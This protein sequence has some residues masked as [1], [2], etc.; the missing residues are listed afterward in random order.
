MAPLTSRSFIPQSAKSFTETGSL[1]T[2]RY[3]HSGTVLADGRVL[4]AGGAHCSPPH[5]PV[6]PEYCWSLSSAELYE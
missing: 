4:I 5:P 1:N 6:V 3:G 2:A